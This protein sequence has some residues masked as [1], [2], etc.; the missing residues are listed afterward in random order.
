MCKIIG[1]RKSECGIKK[2]AY[3]ESSGYH[4]K[5]P[6]EAA[7]TASTTCSLQIIALKNISNTVNISIIFGH[8]EALIQFQMTVSLPKLDHRL[9]FLFKMQYA[10]CYKNVLFRF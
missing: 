3:P 8:D 2:R 4:K 6:V 10:N 1:I 7:P 9:L 5:L